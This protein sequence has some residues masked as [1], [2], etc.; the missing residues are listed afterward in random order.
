MLSALF[1]VYTAAAGAVAAG[2]VWLEIVLR[3]P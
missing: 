2:L 1:W 3:R